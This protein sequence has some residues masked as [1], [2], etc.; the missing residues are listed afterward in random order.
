[1]LL[2]TLPTAQPVDALGEE[3]DRSVL[4]GLTP[5]TL[6]VETRNSVYTVVVHGESHDGYQMATVVAPAHTITGAP[7]AILSGVTCRVLD[8]RLVVVDT[9]DIRRTVLRTSDIMAT[10][11]LAVQC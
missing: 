6:L 2:D 7:G 5:A 8:N 1:M 11:L 3:C 9:D 10:H 4:T